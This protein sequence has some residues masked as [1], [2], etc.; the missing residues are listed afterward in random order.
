MDPF[1]AA[2]P[3]L[4]FHRFVPMAR[5]A[6]MIYDGSVHRRRGT[7]WLAADRLRRAPERLT[8]LSLQADA[9]RLPRVA[10]E[11][12]SRGRRGDWTLD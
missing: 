8:S 7:L 4:K 5:I 9:G 11:A 10:S 1:G 6:N 2:S 12:W 3:A